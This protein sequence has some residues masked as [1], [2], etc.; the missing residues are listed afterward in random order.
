VKLLWPFSER[1]F[2]LDILS[3]FDLWALFLLL[4]GILLPMLFR[5]VAEEIGAKR[6]S[7]SAAV[8]AALALT[9]V[10]AYVG[11]RYILHMRALD[12]LNSRLYQGEAPSAVGA[13]PD[14]PSPTQ[15]AGIVATEG[16]LLKVNVPVAFGAFDPF[17][18]KRFFKPAPSAALDA[19]RATRTAALF[20]GFARFPR[21]TVERNDRGFRVEITDMRFEVGSPPHKSMAA[22]IDLS[23]QAQV[24]SEELKFGDLFQR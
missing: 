8:S 12:L 7:K 21:A 2:A 6:K 14:S 9:L 1:W 18:A 15:W 19:A 16:A 10:F 3:A 5:L 11:G 13:F 17:S 20:L 23:A 24:I 22:V 4:A